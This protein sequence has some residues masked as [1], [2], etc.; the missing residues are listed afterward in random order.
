M[1][2]IVIEGLTKKYKKNVALDNIN[3][4]VGQGEIFGFIG[5]NGAGKSTTI[6]CL[7]DFIKPTKGIA[8][9]Y[10][11]DAQKDSESLKRIIGYVPS[12]VHYY[13]NVTVEEILK[14]TGKFHGIHNLKEMMA[15][16]VERFELEP[17]KKMKELSLGNR[18]KVAIVNSLIFDPEV[19]ILDE[20]TSGLDPLMQHRLFEEL[21]YHH[22]EGT[23]IFLS[24]HNLHEV[25]SFCT[26]TAFIRSGK[27][28]SVEEMETG[29]TPAKVVKLTGAALQ[30][31]ALQAKGYRVLSR[32]DTD[33]SLLYQDSVKQLLTDLSFLEIDDVEIRNQ[34]LEEKFLSLYDGGE[35]HE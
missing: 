4:T 10:G 22:D 23:T 7:L 18:K 15:Y 17:K 6:K 2:A 12:D 1:E 3:L 11:L 30:V 33:V 29:H 13:N 5:P 32:T 24:T 35:L 28:L 19:L 16:Y 8:E 9:I 27:I 31:E 25:E 34:N 21:S 26:R 14:M 20:P